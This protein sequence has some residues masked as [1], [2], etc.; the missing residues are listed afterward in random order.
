M[1]KTK[2]AELLVAHKQRL[3]DRYGDPKK[4]LKLICIAAIHGNEQAGIL[5]LKQVFE[6]M[7]QQQLELNGELIALIGNLQAVRQNTRFIE[8][9]LNR[10]WSDTAIS[11]ALAQ[12]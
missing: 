6:R 12:R 9:D 11:D 3:I 5:A 10:I 7:R 4:P 1:I 2:S 8:R